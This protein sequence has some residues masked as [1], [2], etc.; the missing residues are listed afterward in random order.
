M[1]LRPAF[2]APLAAILPGALFS[3]AQAPKEAALKEFEKRRLE[4]LF[5]SGQRHLE[6]GAEIRK[7]GLT[8]QSAEQLLLAVEASE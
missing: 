5:R 3:L 7:R 4:G 8:T 2:L 1:S 6:F